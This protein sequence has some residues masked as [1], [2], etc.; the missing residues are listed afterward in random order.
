MPSAGFPW[1]AGACAAVG[2]A[3]AWVAAAGAWVAAAGASV[4]GAAG[5]AAVWQAEASAAPNTLPAPTVAADLRK[6]RRFSFW[7]VILILLSLIDMLPFHRGHKANFSP[8]AVL[9]SSFSHLLCLSWQN[10]GPL[11]FL[12]G[13][14]TP[15]HHVLRIVAD[16]MVVLHDG[17]DTAV[18]RDSER[19]SQFR[20]YLVLVQAAHRQV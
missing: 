10:S 11:G 13:N 6:S 8:L 2:A 16:G 7:L 18:P 14:L 15:T 5:V 1:A 17:L 9:C 20:P 12:A 3:G 19:L 4:A